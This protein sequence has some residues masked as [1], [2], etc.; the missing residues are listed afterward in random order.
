MLKA[1]KLF[2]SDF[3]ALS[4]S[5]KETEYRRSIRTTRGAL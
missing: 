4:E 3:I 5:I 1:S 2:R